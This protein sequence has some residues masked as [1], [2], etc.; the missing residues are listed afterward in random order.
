MIRHDAAPDYFALC[1]LRVHMRAMLDYDAEE[2]AL[3]PLR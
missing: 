3:M 1:A 2:S